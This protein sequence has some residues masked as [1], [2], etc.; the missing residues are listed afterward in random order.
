MLLTSSTVDRQNVYDNQG[1]TVVE[2]TPDSTLDLDAAGIAWTIRDLA[3]ANLLKI[4]EGSGSG[5][6]EIQFGPDVD[7]FTSDAAVN[8]FDSGASLNV[9]G[10]RPVDVGVSDGVVETTA[11]D[12]RLAAA[13]ELLLDDAN[14]TSSTWAQTGGIK[15]SEDTAEWDNFEVAFGEV[16]LL[17]AIVQ[18]NG[19]GGGGTVVK[20]C[21]KV[22]ATI[23]S[24]DTDVSLSDGNLDASLGNLSGGNFV[25]DHDVF[26]N[27]NLLLSGATAATNNDVYPG[28]SLAAGQLR[29]EFKLKKNDVI[30]VLSRA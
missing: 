12:L 9:G 5:T 6:S 25:D 15:L 24:A 10:T 16:S 20:A 2:V 4:L 19:G 3:N 30:C 26:L 21:A 28:T 23:V 27:G 13:A 29:F 11:G 7:T 14:Q 1:I 22:T 8:T 18:A 17:N